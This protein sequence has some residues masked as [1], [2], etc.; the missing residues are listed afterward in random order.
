MRSGVRVWSGRL[1][2]ES[3]G[4]VGFEVFVRFVWS[5]VYSVKYSA[6]PVFLNGNRGTLFG[7]SMDFLFKRVHD[8]VATR[9]RDFVLRTISRRPADCTVAQQTMRRAPIAVPNIK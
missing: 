9:Y 1:A 3:E 8:R 5:L 2:R 4:G 7:C 6:P